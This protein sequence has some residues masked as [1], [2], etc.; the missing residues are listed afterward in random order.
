[1]NTEITDNISNQV[2]YDGDC[3]LCTAWARR[4]ERTLRR[5]GFTL[6]PLQAAGGAT[7]DLTEMRVVTRDG[8]FGGADALVQLARRIWWATPL[9]V[10]AQFPGAMPLLR[11]GYRWLAKNR[12]CLGGKCRVRNEI[13]L[14]DWLPLVALPMGTIFCRHLL[15]PWLFMW[16]LAFALYAG[17]KWL[18]FSIARRKLRNVTPARSL[19]YL[20]AWPGMDAAAFLNP[21][22]NA[23]RPGVGEWAFAGAKI[24]IGAMLFWFNAPIA[25][26]HN[27]IL[28][29]W[30]GMV[31]IIFCVHFGV[32]H[33]S[34]LAWRAAGVN[35]TPLMR[36]PLLAPSLAEFW[37][38]RWNTAF[39][40]LVHRFLFRPLLRRTNA[41]MAMLLVFLGSG[42]VHDLVISFP[43]HGGYG[44]P[45]AYFLIQGLGLLVERTTIA[46]KIG[47]G[48]GVR[49]L[50]FTLF[51]TVAPVFWLFHPPFIRTVILPML[52]AIGAT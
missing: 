52:H 2:L 8:N 48:H 39:H 30:I 9:F 47:L 17:C 14:R 36:N 23:E 4:F 5:R 38:K 19:G 44:L 31:G 37:G 42:L 40:D 16:A 22:K 45:T 43:A 10:A 49:G 27:V 18:T 11:R 12:Y 26:H 34:A 51:V 29:G 6:R 21:V 24:A 35:A 1:M 46:V 3:A 13:L 28:T 7:V 41:A 20:L 33:L 32:L 25:A 15:A 50:L